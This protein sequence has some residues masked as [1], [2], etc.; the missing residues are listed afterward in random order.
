M[1]QQDF[2]HIAAALRPRLLKL[3]ARFF[4]SPHWLDDLAHIFQVSKPFVDFLNDTIDDYD[5]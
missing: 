1:A 4:D 5:L 2:Q 3:C